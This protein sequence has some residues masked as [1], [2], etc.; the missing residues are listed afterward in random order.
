M[1][2]YGVERYYF[3]FSTS[4]EKA[5]VESARSWKPR[6]E[7]DLE[8]CAYFCHSVQ[9]EDLRKTFLELT[10]SVSPIEIYSTE[11]TSPLKYLLSIYDPIESKRKRSGTSSHSQKV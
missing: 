2:A 8:G 10:E 6:L 11:F 9:I 1:N 5:F 3:K 7:S 4:D